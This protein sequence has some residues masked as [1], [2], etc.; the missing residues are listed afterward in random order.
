M[1]SR[2]PV[3]T[4]VTL[5][6]GHDELGVYRVVDLSAGGALLEGRCPVPLGHEVTARLHFS[7]FEVVA[8]A[9]AVRRDHRDGAEVFAVSFELMAP[10][11]RDCVQ[12]LVEVSA[13]WAPTASSQVTR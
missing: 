6:L 4:C 13:D 2:A 7:P 5:S 3:S 11:V 10:E 8:G 1:F 9:V 12:R